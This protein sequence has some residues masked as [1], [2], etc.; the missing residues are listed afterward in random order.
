MSA[1]LFKLDMF[2]GPLDLLLHLITKHK[3]NIYDIEIAVLLE[4]YLEYMEGLEEE[5]FED[6]ADFLEMAARLI[7]IKTASLLPRENEGEELKKELQG[8]LIEYS[9]CKMAAAKLKEI[10]AGGEIF[11][12]QP[13]KLPVNK[14]FTGTMDKQKL[15]DAYLGMSAKA[16]K[17][18]PLRA[19][20]FSPIVSHRIVSVTSKIIHVLKML[21]TQ[22]ECFLTS[23]YDGCADKS[24]RVAVFL[25]VLEL[26]KSGR[27]FLNDD[28]TRVYM[29]S[30]AKKRKIVSHFDEAEIEAEE[31]ARA[32]NSALEEVTAPY[33]GA[34]EGEKDALTAEEKPSQAEGEDFTA[35]RYSGREN[36]VFSTPVYP[37]AMMPYIPST[38][39]R[40]VYKSETRQ[41][42]ALPVLRIELSPT[43]QKVVDEGRQD[44]PE[45][46]RA[47]MAAEKPENSAFGG[48]TVSLVKP[49]G[50]G[51]GAAVMVGADDKSV[52][53]DLAEKPENSAFGGETVSLVKP[54]DAGEGAAVMVGADDKS[55]G[56]D[57]AEK[58]ENSA[59]GGET[60]SLV[61][62]VD[63]GEG[64]AVM[65]GADDKSVGADLAEKP[66]NSAFGGE[67]V[68]LVKPVGAGEGSAVMVGAD[69]KS[70]GADLAEKP[71]NSAFGGETVSLV[72]P[73]GAGEGAAVAMTA[74]GTAESEEV[75]GIDETAV[76]SSDV[77]PFPIRENLFAVRYYWGAK[78]WSAYRARLG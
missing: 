53:A 14:T 34:E 30:A 46:M 78:S 19:E 38:T 18:K 73:V 74:E 52:G 1:A 51:E 26:T 68:S 69:D 25:A 23:M 48:E 32:A 75:N 43:L 15:Y 61:K 13:M 47:E 50:A 36:G 7:Y 4:Q 65:V 62:P 42:G 71:E 63:A 33:G 16:R 21:I 58:P 3:L 54:V 59:F 6:A 72:K 66:E 31:A 20:M 49:V 44:M 24:E 12:R 41:R 40:T 10:Y 76:I 60:V 8:S 37:Q 67:T 28:N 27:I 77:T 22:G 57:L 70:V 55:V 64:A 11:V 9:L 17:V 45:D 29:N 39:E 56:A 5:D 35:D 2:E